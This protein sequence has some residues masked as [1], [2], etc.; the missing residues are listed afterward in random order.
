[1]DIK[2]RIEK[3][4]NVQNVLEMNRDRVYP[5][6]MGDAHQGGNLKGV[7]WYHLPTKTFLYSST[8]NSHMDSKAFPEI[9]NL[10]HWVRGRVFTNNGQ[11]FVL[12][13]SDDFTMGRVPGSI[14]DAIF[15]KITTK[16]HQPITDFVDERG[17]SLI[18]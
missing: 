16:F 1:M 4:K 12:M 14:V 10:E 6:A 15:Q 11:N 18:G 2:E 8:A 9:N 5:D 13:Y 7:W 17:Y 3:I